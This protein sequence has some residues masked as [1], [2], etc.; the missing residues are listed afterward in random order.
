MIT[1]NGY[2][3]LQ[4]D[5]LITS[6]LNL[7]NHSCQIYRNTGLIT[8]VRYQPSKDARLITVHRNTASQPHL[9]CGT[10]FDEVGT[11]CKDVHVWWRMA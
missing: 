1:R 2:H 6:I 8:Q 11:K 5:T 3:D 7:G 10:V 4:K 9:G